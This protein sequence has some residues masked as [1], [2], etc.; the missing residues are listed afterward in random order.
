M[1]SRILVVLFLYIF[2]ILCH[3]RMWRDDIKFPPFRNHEVKSVQRTVIVVEVLIWIIP[4][5]IFFQ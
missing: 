5:L 2:T 4:L 3:V 1:D